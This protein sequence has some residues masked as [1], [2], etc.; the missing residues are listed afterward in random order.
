MK[1][2]EKKMDNQKDKPSNED[3]KLQKKGSP[4]IQSGSSKK[5]SK[6]FLALGI[7]LTAAILIIGG[8]AAY[9]KLHYGSRWYKNTIINGVNV[10]GQTLEESKKNLIQAHNN[11][12]LTIKARNNGSMTIDDDAINYRFGIGS[13]FDDIFSEQH[14]QFHLF[15]SKNNY[16]INFDV[17]YNQKKLSKLLKESELITGSSSYPIVKPR[18]ATVSYS[19]EKQQYVCVQEI[20]GNKLLSAAFLATVEDTLKKAETT[21]DLTDEKKHP[22]VYKAPKLTSDDEELQT[23]LKLSNNAALRYVTWNM[24]EGVKEEITPAEISQWITYK[25]GKIK[26]DNEAISDWIESFCLKYKTVGKTRTITS[27]NKKRIKI[28][29]GDYGWQLDYEKTLAQAKKALKASI[30]TSLTEAYINEPTNENKKALTLKR[31]VI[32]ANT[33][34]KKD[35]ENF[36]NDWDT[37]NYTEISIKDQKVYVFRKGKVVFSCRCITGLPV[38]GRST[39]TGA[40]YI[41]EHREEYTLTGADYSTPVTN[42]VRITWTGTGFHPATWQPW[43]SWNKE[44]YKT[45]GSHGCINLAVPDAAKIYKLTKYRE[46]VFIH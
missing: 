23:A 16:T 46:A 17:S 27:H 38:E 41:K 40:F 37:E 32:Y 44:L 43:S 7:T 26:Y 42:W 14:N 31:K 12:T 25:N 35:Y 6:T 3:V 8:L 22:D 5:P 24:G 36:I 10:S 2:T 29:G 34:F 11:Y 30:D 19:E 18:A 39:P 20:N 15:S 45:R 1:T 9:Q 4:P 28:Y 33:A 21:L 13:D